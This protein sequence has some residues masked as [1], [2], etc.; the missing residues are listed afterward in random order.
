LE[1]SNTHHGELNN[2]DI[3]I[4]III[5]RFNEPVVEN[6]LKGAV[7]AFE[8]NGVNQ[9]NIDIYYVPGAFEIP[10]LLKKIC[11]KNTE[12]KKFDGILTIG[13][14]IKGETAHFEYIS[15]TVSDSIN[16]ISS[17]FEMPLGFC[18]LTCYTP[19]QAYERSIIPPDSKNNKGFESALT[20][21]EMISLM[22]KI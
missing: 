14:V 6:L 8:L 19:L 1:K 9:S 5:S 20:L 15:G 22:N 13:C 12:N 3:K 10:A 7:S 18:V 17:E 11:R 2:A 21:M 16:K 4:G